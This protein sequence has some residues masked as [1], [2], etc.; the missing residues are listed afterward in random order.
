M[1]ADAKA[2]VFCMGK[3]KG[4]GRKPKPT[5]L[6]VLH[7]TY[8]TTRHGRNRDGEVVIDAELEKPELSPRAGDHWDHVV[9]DLDAAGVL[10]SVDQDA[11]KLY[12]ETWVQWDEAN[13]G[14]RRH[15]V[16]IRSP[17][18]KKTP[19]L[20]PYFTASLKTADMLRR[21]LTEFGMT[22]VSRTGLKREKPEPEPDAGTLAAFMRNNAG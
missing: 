15:G 8:N 14:V 16:I 2:T 17:K 22:P 9:A 3:V 21:L 6:H 4:A 11:L 20:S 7:G 1:E 5:T 19:I 13:E 12:C 18:D 10:G